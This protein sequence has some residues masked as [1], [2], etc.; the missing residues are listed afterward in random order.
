MPG[1][2]GADLPW[3]F[4]VFKFGAKDQVLARAVAGCAIAGYA[5]AGTRMIT[6]W[7]ALTECSDVQPVTMKCARAGIAI[8]GYAHAGWQICACSTTQWAEQNRYN[9]TMPHNECEDQ[10]G[11]N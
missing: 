2:G 3:Q 1:T 5:K 4:A 9:I 6:S 10:N 11:N 8:S 7:D